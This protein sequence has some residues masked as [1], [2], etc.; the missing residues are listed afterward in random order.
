[1]ENKKQT[2]VEFL[3]LQLI[4][5]SIITNNDLKQAKEMEKQQIINGRI[6]A[7]ITT[8]DIELDRQEG[9]QYYKEEYGS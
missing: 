5:N 1:M 3:E 7:P 6:T 8:G 2:A 4:K 9:E